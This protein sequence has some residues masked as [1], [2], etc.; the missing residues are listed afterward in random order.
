[1]ASVIMTFTGVL[2]KVRTDVDPFLLAVYR[3]SVIFVCS[4]PRLIQQNIDVVPQGGGKVKFLFARAFFT[5]FV[6]TSLFYSFRYM[7]LGDARTISSTNP[8]FTSIFACCLLKRSPSACS[9]CSCW[10]PP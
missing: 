7:P 3:S 10:S 6:T 8:I 2:V 9:R 5:S 1:M 4:M